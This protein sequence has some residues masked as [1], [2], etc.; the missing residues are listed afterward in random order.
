[1]TETAR[2]SPWP[3]RLAAASAVF[4]VALGLTVLAGWFSD[5]PALIQ[6]LPQ[7]PPMTRNAA[8]CFL[9]CGLAL[10]IAAVQGPRWL[11]L[12][13]AGTVGL[14][15]PLGPGASIDLRF[16]F[17]VQQTGPFRFYLNIEVLP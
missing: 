13:C 4:I 12:A 15:S 5:T 2:V 16:L 11:V 1:M 7:L 17:G 6:L 8:A 3:T 14:V 10:G 9:L